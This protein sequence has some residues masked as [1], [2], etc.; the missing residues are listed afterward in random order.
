MGRD[1]LRDAARRLA[2]WAPLVLAAFSLA[3]CGGGGSTAPDKPATVIPAD[4]AITAPAQAEEAL[5]QP[6]SSSAAALS[7]LKFAWNFGDGG[8]SAEASPT[9]AFAAPGAYTVKLTVSNDGGQSREVTSAVNVARFKPSAGASCG[10]PGETGWCLLGGARRIAP[11]WEADGRGWYGNE[12]GEIHASTDGGKTWTRAL[13]QDGGAVLALYADAKAVRALTDRGW[14]WKSTDRGATWTH[15]ESGQS[16]SVQARSK[17]LPSLQAVGDSTVILDKAWITQDDGLTWRALPAGLLDASPDG[18][19][20]FRK[21]KEVAGPGGVMN[22]EFFADELQRSRDGGRTLTTVLTTPTLG[23]GR[24]AL[25]ARSNTKLLAMAPVN[26]PGNTRE[27]WQWSTEDGGEHW[28]GEA[29]PGIPLSPLG[30]IDLDLY[31]SESGADWAV[32]QSGVFRRPGA[33]QPWALV[34]AA[35]EGPCAGQRSGD[36]GLALACREAF[37]LTTDGGLTWHGETSYVNLRTPS[38]GAVSL[39]PASDWWTSRRLTRLA[40]GAVALGVNGMLALSDDGGDRWRAA[41]GPLDLRQ[42]WMTD[43]RNGWAFNGSGDLLNTVDGGRHWAVKSAPVVDRTWLNLW[44]VDGQHG[45][46]NAVTGQ[47]ARSEDG[48][49]SWQS[50]TV[51]EAGYFDRYQFFDS[52]RGVGFRSSNFRTTSDGGKTWTNGTDLPIATRASLAF[53]SANV[54]LV[55]GVD[56]KVART[57]DGGR[58]WQVVTVAPAWVKDMVFVDDNIVL[59]IAAADTVARST[60]AGQSWS[61]V[62]V[63]G[64]VDS[65]R[66][67]TAGDGRTLWLVGSAGQIFRSSDAG[68]NWQLQ[69]PGVLAPALAQTRFRDAFFRDAQ[70]GWLV[71]DIGRLWVTDSGGE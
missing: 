47:L 55:A 71:D 51:G 54:G 48:G 65:S 56:G 1:S 5:A 31:A 10:K 63:A 62:R 34:H 57:A 4:L 39:E 58:T 52:N 41:L 64:L 14:V 44:F 53:R 60:D 18:T 42:V 30:A 38:N 7:G 50:L 25:V 67:R 61:F 6:W 66:L 36:A 11:L 46:L 59:A 17:V 2:A 23:Y 69:G 40:S 27:Y 28:T 32:L 9:H 29:A 21:P 45:W 70:T 49:Q 15:T 12:L 68:L 37:A 13:K 19:L 22:G 26:A 8:S 24:L 16:Y 3:G 35:M 20:W 43:R 33:G